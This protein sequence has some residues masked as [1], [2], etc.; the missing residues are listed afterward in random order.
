M[1]KNKP[2]TPISQEDFE[3]ELKSEPKVFDALTLG[4]SPKDG[5][6]YNI[7]TVSVASKGLQIGELK[8][9]DTAESKSEAIEKFKLNAI[10][11]KVI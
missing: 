1:S 6:G 3:A 5:G 10:R 2:K 9:I 7:V 11:L 4:M 8:V